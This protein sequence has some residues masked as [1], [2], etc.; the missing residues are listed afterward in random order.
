MTMSLSGCVNVIVGDFL[1]WFSDIEHLKEELSCIVKQRNSKNIYQRVIGKNKCF[2][3]S[4]RNKEIY[5]GRLESECLSF[6]N[7][8]CLLASF[9]VSIVNQK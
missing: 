7:A 1:L 2:S 9:H 6:G 3:L 4:L 5:C 8:F